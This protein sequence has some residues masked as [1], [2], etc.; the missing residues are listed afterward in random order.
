MVAVVE[1]ADVPVGAEHAQEFEQ[2]AGVFRKLK[3]VQTLG[4]WFGRATTNHVAN[5]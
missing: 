4:Q 3:A 2:C 5:V 1:Q